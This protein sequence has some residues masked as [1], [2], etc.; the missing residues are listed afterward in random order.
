MKKWLLLLALISSGIFGFKQ[1]RASQIGAIAGE[2]VSAEFV[3]Q[4]FVAA[5]ARR[6][7]HDMGTLHVGTQTLHLTYSV[8]VRGAGAVDRN[9]FAPSIGEVQRLTTFF[10]DDLKYV[11]DVYDCDD[12][13]RH[14]KDRLMHQWAKEGNR[15]PLAIVEVYAAIV[16]PGHSAPLLH[17]FNAVVTNEGKVV[18]IEPQVPVPMAFRT[19]QIVEIFNAVM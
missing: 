19:A 18:F 10:K 6:F 9:Y 7:D 5:V 11:P 3:A 14:F 4:A 8:P 16:I 15:V 13:S 17:A 1:Y 12:F 2:V